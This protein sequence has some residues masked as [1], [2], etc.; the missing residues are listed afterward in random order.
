MGTSATSEKGSSWANSMLS[1]ALIALLGTIVGALLAAGVEWRN[2]E[3]EKDTANRD[4]ELD[5]ARFK[6]EII[7]A[8]KNFDRDT[9]EVLLEHTIKEIDSKDRYDRFYTDYQNLLAKLQAGN[10]PRASALVTSIKQSGTPPSTQ[11]Q[12]P[13]TLVN[14]FPGPDRRI[15]AQQLVELY[16]SQTKQVI[17]AL[18]KGILPEL[19]Q[20]AYRVNLYIAYTLAMIKPHWSGTSSQL[21]ELQKLTKN[22]NYADKTFKLR[23][24]QAIKN[25]KL[26]RS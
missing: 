3:V 21:E 2:T 6:G 11:N 1:A 14:L 20:N 18:I 22:A 26:A 12:S 24:D 4:R 10:D 13:E 7:R 5:L 17:D 9:A 25:I 16:S 8:I 19:D 23:V 15:A